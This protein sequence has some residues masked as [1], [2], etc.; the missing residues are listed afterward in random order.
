MRP[1]PLSS[2]HRESLHTKGN[3]QLLFVIGAIFGFTLAFA[4]QRLMQPEEDPDIAHY[5]EVRDFVTRNFVREVDPDRAL[6]HALQGML[7]SLDDYSRYYDAPD[8]EQLNR[9]TG[10]RYTGIGVVLKRPLEEGRILFTLPGSPAQRAGIRVGDRIVAVDGEPVSQ[11]FDS[12]VLRRDLDD[13]RRAELVIEVEGLDGERR[14]VEVPHASLVDPTVRHERIVDAELGIGYLAITSFSHETPGE[15]LDAFQALRSRGM[16]ALVID[17]R[18]NFGGVLT[19][20]VE[21]AQR[22]I[23]EGTIVSTEGRGRPEVHRADASLA[24]FEGFPLVVIVDRNSASASEVLAAALQDHRAAAVVGS[25]TYGKGMVQ[26]IHRFPERGTI[27][28]ITTSFYY[29][30]SHR[31]LEHSFDPGRDYGILP[32]LLIDLER[33]ERYAIYEH[34]SRYSAPF[35]SRAAIRAWEEASNETLIDPH[36]EDLQLEAALALLRG[37]RPG[38]RRLED[39]G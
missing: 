28:K 38:P 25:P 32:D 20:S 5:R 18:A 39:E 34:L 35:A 9:E 7:S 2:R 29:T 3:T 21:I 37:E 10:G 8:A 1:A 33:E 24:L 31:N 13:P 15:F 23:P 22:F 4:L 19:A 36:P 27:A 11:P 30:P 6:D 26:T 14:T 17:L 16:K 12:A